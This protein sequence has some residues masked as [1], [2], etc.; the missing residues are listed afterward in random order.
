MAQ[1]PKATHLTRPLKLLIGHPRKQRRHSQRRSHRLTLHRIKHVS[2]PRRQR[3]NLRPAHPHRGKHRT[4]TRR[5]KKRSHNQKTILT[6]R[7]PP[8]QRSPGV[9]H[10]IPMSK[11]HTLGLTRSPPGIENPRKVTLTNPHTKSH[12][13]SPGNSLL[14][15]IRQPDHMLEQPVQRARLTV[16]QQNPRPR[17]SNRILK[18]SQSTPGIQRDNDKPSRRNTQISLQIPVT[19]RRNHSNPIPTNKPQTSQITR[20]PTTTRPQH[21][22][23]QPNRATHNRLPVRRRQPRMLQRISNRLHGTHRPAS[24]SPVD[25]C[26]RGPIQ[27]PQLGSRSCSSFL[28]GHR[29][30]WHVCP[31]A[32]AAGAGRT[33][34][35][36]AEPA[37]CVCATGPLPSG[38]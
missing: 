13:L 2:R 33:R 31:M 26:S 25:R 30:G 17:V 34:S 35:P 10:Q 7:T 21:L 29:Q 36:S 14:I 6:R 37:G 3:D 5:M 9:S 27:G 11:H 28:F 12:R 8:V 1:Q 20:Q 22:I 4:R 23:I 18:L 24:A 32:P 38:I 19:V 16:S 15:T